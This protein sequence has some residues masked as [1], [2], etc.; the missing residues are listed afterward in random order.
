MVSYQPNQADLTPSVNNNRRIDL[1]EL[2]KK[3]K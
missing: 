3:K 1:N 2:L